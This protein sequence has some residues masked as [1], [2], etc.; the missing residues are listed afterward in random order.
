MYY[1]QSPTGEITQIWYN[2]DD[3]PYF[4]NVKLGAINSFQTH[5]VNVGQYEQKLEK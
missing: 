3:S 5:I 4:I 1:Q 2:E